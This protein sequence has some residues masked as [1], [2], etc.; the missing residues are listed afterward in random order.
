M[1][2]TG[3]KTIHVVKPRSLPA[4]SS[5]RV[6]TMKRT[7]AG[8][9]PVAALWIY[10]RTQTSALLFGKYQAFMDSLLKDTALR[11][12]K[13]RLPF[14]GVDRYLLLKTASEVWLMGECGV[15]ESLDAFRM[16][17]PAGIDVLAEQQRLDY[18]LDKNTAQTLCNSYLKH[19][20]ATGH[21]TLPYLDLI[22][23]KLKGTALAM[24]DKTADAI[25]SIEEKLSHPPMIELIWSYWIEESMLVQTMNA[26]SLRFQ[27]R[28][29]S[30]GPDPLAHLELDPLRPINTMLWG[31]IQDEQHRLSVPRRSFE[32]DHHYGIS[33]MGKAVNDQRTADSR[34]KFLSAFH[35]LLYL[36]SEFYKRDDDTTVVSD[37]FP[38]LNALKEVHLI[39]TQGAHNQYGD[40]PWTA[41]LEMLMEQWLLSRPEM[42]EFLPGRIMVD[43]P[44]PWMERV[45]TMK[46]LQG[47]TDT[48]VLHFRDLAI[49][50]E[51]II[52]GIRYHNWSDENLADTAKGWARY[53]RP[54]IQGY[55][56]AYRAVTGVDLTQ[57]KPDSR[58][59]A[60]HLQR[61][62][63][64]QWRASGQRPELRFLS[65][66]FR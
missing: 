15:W 34:S 24:E 27:N 49:F 36:C 2:I 33:L 59:P 44:E 12:S 46:K 30:A 3:N 57:D 35:N 18:G 55:I 61:R 14:P 29:L 28:R 23:A 38:V 25:A 8:L 32:Y 31:Y 9:S 65:R 43:Y 42:R 39:V 66:A 17:F 26:I 53:W 50:G 16:K 41:R 56:H 47:W 48:S 1:E 7:D 58:L 21:T 10:I 4:G 62:L 19:D 64:E 40:L 54:E 60:V 5:Q 45:E 13:I 52:L 11:G 63:M 6:V 37:A 20:E 22:R 51:Q